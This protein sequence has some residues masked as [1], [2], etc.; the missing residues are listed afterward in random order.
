MKK[1]MNFS[2]FQALGPINII[3]LQLYNFKAGDQASR[4]IF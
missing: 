3:S 2:L 1:G 4:Q